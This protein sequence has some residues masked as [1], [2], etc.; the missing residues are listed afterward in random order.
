MFAIKT[1]NVTQKEYFAQLS[2]ILIKTIS[3]HATLQVVNRA[4][5]EKA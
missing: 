1:S 3:I 4:V 5:D 2:D